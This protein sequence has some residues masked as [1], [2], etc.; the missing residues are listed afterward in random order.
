MSKEKEKH[1][2]VKESVHKD[3]KLLAFTE[4]L[5]MG[6]Y[7]EKVIDDKKKANEATK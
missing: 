3:I 6:A 2:V 1:I 7:L 4:G 5:T